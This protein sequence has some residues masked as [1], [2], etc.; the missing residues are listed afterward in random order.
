MSESVSAE[1]GISV[2]PPI[3]SSLKA[4]PHPST[5]ICVICGFLITVSANPRLSADFLF[6]S[7]RVH[8]RLAFI[9]VNLRP[10]AVG[11]SIGVHSRLHLL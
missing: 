11:R 2:A 6:V 8:S 3:Y 4:Q 1:A 9:C 5:E 10:S 7:I